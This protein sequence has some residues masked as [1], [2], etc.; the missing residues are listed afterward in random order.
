MSDPESFPASGTER[1]IVSSL[2]AMM[3]PALLLNFNNH[4]SLR[5]L[6]SPRI[7]WILVQSEM[8]AAVV[9]V[10]KI[11]SKPCSKGFFVD[12]ADEVIEALSACGSNQELDTGCLPGSSRGRNHWGVNSRSP[13]FQITELILIRKLCREFRYQTARYL[14]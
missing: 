8:T 13:P 1:P 10:R 2:V 14:Y 5:W 12:C 6:H 4:T 11:G 9:V 3:R 7:R